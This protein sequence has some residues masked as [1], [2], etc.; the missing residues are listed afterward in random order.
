[1]LFAIDRAAGDWAAA[2]G[3]R[4]QI[5]GLLADL[6]QGEALLPEGAIWRVTAR[7]TISGTQGT[8]WLWC[9]A[10]QTGSGR[11]AMARGPLPA[12]VADWPAEIAVEAGS[13]RLQLAAIS[14]LAP[15]DLVVLDLLAHPDGATGNG[16]ARLV[17]GAFARAIRWLDG[18]RFE[19][20]SPAGGSHV[21]EA[22]D[23]SGDPFRVE[24][25]GPRDAGGAPDVLVRVEV[26]R[27]RMTVGQ[28]MGL[29]PG[30][31]VELERPVG[32]EVVLR[33]GDGRIAAG[34]LVEHEGE[35]AVEITDVP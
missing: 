11:P 1:L 32:A 6:E 25:A 9:A 34:V 27:V 33:V 19:L 10:P 18:T 31:V 28:A 14:G 13:S 7:L 17:S 23:E 5:R 15:G 29:L 16:N 35:L 22:Q 20:V 4:F 24:T 3:A 30:R 2:G 26:A 21:M 12:L 8:V